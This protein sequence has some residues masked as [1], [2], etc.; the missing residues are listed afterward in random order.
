LKPAADQK[1]K[2]VNLPCKVFRLKQHF[3][4]DSSKKTLAMKE[5]VGQ[6]HGVLLGNKMLLSL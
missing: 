3:G 2:D 4:A 1:Y 6:Q 5:H